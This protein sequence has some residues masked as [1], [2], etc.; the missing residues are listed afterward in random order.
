MEYRRLGRT[1]LRASCLDN[2]VGD[3]IRD[4]LDTKLRDQ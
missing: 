3:G 2:L 4:A 1:G